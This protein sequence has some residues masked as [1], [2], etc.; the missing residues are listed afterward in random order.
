MGKKH[1]TVINDFTKVNGMTYYQKNVEEIIGAIEQVY[2]YCKLQYKIY[3]FEYNVFTGTNKNNIEWFAFSFSENQ[4]INKDD[5]VIALDNFENGSTQLRIHYPSSLVEKVR[6]YGG[7]R[8]FYS[9]NYF[10]DD[11]TQYVREIRKIMEI[12]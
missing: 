10:F 7:Q 6:R 12:I 3:F 1:S 4:D 8:D 11:E 2:M 5:L 9:L